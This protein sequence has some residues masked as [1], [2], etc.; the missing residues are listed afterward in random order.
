MIET[1]EDRRML[2]ATLADSATASA[3]AHL[4]LAPVEASLN[5]GK[6]KA[7]VVNTTTPS[8]VHNYFGKLKTSGV[9]FGFGSRQLDFELL[10]TDQTLTSITGHFSVGGNSGDGTL[11]GFEKTN[12]RFSYSIKTNGFTF[13]MDGKVSNNG[14][15]LGGHASVKVSSVSLF[16]ASGGFVVN[17]NT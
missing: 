3:A 12:G 9:I 15:T 10:I 5:A 14:N 11:K 13:K 7:K 6:A 2:S 17:A 1:L 4:G 8:L 16:R